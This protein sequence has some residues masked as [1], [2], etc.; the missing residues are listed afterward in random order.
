MK[1]LTDST[2]ATKEAHDCS[3]NMNQCLYEKFRNR[4]EKLE[5]EKKALAA[6][7]EP[8]ING[9]SPLG[10]N[11][12]P[13]N[14]LLE[15]FINEKRVEYERP[16]EDTIREVFALLSHYLKTEVV[17]IA[18]LYPEL[19]K[20][21]IRFSKEIMTEIKESTYNQLKQFFKQEKAFGVNENRLFYSEIEV[22]K[23]SNGV[24][25][26]SDSGNYENESDEVESDD[27]EENSELDKDNFE[28]GEDEK[29]AIS[30]YLNS[31]KQFMQGIVPKTQERENA[32]I[33]E[34]KTKKTKKNVDDFVEIVMAW[35]G[36]FRRAIM[37]RLPLIVMTDPVDFID[38]ELE[39]KSVKF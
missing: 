25:G 10:N 2:D 39:N 19:H 36:D 24:K 22:N 30:E 26:N 28:C 15:N 3:L 14:K 20:L 32:R 34:V 33:L 23:S 29:T 5:L 37:D 7:T 31:Q 17:S 35:H 1:Y 8:K 12:F 11:I 6:E 38:T 9:F 4:I 21:L 27:S 16:C 13:S 18:K